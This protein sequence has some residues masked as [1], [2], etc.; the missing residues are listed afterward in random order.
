MTRR[1]LLLVAT[2]AAAGLTGFRVGGA[3]PAKANPFV[4]EANAPARL[5]NAVILCGDVKG[6]SIS[7]VLILLDGKDRA[8]FTGAITAKSG[9][10]ASASGADTVTVKLSD[11]VV[12]S[13][14]AKGTGVSD[15]PV[16]KDGK[17]K[18]SISPVIKGKSV[19]YNATPGLKL[20]RAG[21]LTLALPTPAA[22]K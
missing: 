12:L 14:D 21:E 15:A 1:A 3:D 19:T 17:D 20:M 18:A 22:H 9:T 13:D 4:L 11:A 7:D 8:G 16:L 10:Y 6:T 2:M 5:G